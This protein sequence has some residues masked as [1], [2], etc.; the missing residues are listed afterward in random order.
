VVHGSGVRDNRVI[1]DGFNRREGV[2]TQHIWRVAVIAI[3]SA[4]LGLQLARIVEYYAD[5]NPRA[6]ES[7]GYWDRINRGASMYDGTGDR[8]LDTE[9]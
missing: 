8:A 9:D 4:I 1:H 3:I 6:L 7:S 2:M 5:K